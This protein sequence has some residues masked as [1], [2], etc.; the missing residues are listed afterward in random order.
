MPKLNVKFTNENLP[1]STSLRDQIKAIPSLF[2]WAQADS[3]HVTLAGT[4]IT[5]FNDVAGGEVY[6]E[7]VSTARRAD[8]V[9][10]AIGQYS[11]GRFYGST[12]FDDGA[13]DC[14]LAS[15][16]VLTPNTPYS[17]A[18]IFKPADIADAANILSRY[19]DAS[20][21]AALYMT[22]GMEK[23]RFVH[24]SALVDAPV[25]IGSWSYAIASFDG[26][27]INL[28]VNGVA[29]TSTAA[30]GATGGAGLVL[31]A[32]TSAGLQAFDGDISDALVFSGD[33]IGS[34]EYEAIEDY[35]RTVYGL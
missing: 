23:V 32:L 3:A 18:A 15:G 21:R 28:R 9:T 7:P 31:N 4:E 14:Y 35:A 22:G 19:T 5:R 20:N 1:V 13:A 33:I 12:S 16:G 2:T 24:G 34:G 26:T 30:A 25:Q 17:Y 8:L 6:F 10:D 27:N 11:A 29:A